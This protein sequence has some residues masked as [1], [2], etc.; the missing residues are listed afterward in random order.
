MLTLEMEG[1]MSKKANPVSIK[2]PIYGLPRD[3]DPETFTPFAW[4]LAK[5]YEMMGFFDQ[6][7]REPAHVFT[8]LRRKGDE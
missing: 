2:L 6:R 4:D 8:L 3:T 1:K 5:T 7:D